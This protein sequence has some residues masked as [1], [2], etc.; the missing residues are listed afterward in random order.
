MVQEANLDVTLETISEAILAQF[1]AQ[2]VSVI[3]N[4]YVKLGIRDKELFD[5]MSEIAQ[6]IPP[7]VGYCTSSVIYS[8]DMV[9]TRVR[10][11]VAWNR[12]LL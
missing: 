3:V 6:T 10:L 2:A 8:C 5:L 7:L 9:R 12:C 11:Q 4:A 1:N